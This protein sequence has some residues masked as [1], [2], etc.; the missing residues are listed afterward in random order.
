MGTHRSSAVSCKE[1]ILIDINSNDLR[2]LK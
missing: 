1:H 2:V